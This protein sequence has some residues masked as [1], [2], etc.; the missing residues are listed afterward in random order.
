MTQRHPSQSGLLRL[1]LLQLNCQAGEEQE[2]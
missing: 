2:A 1:L